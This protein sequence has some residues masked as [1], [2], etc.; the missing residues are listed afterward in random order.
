MVLFSFLRQVVNSTRIAGCQPRA[1]IIGQQQAI[2]DPLR[3][4]I[5][6]QIAMKTFAMR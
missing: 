4:A 6:P 3:T 1:G 2:R 5:L